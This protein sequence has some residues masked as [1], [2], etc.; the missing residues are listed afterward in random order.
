MKKFVDYIVNIKF[1]DKLNLFL[2]KT[3][4]L[5]VYIF[6]AVVIYKIIKFFLYK[7][8]ENKIS[9]KYISQKKLSL[10]HSIILNLIKYIIYFIAILIILKKVFNINPALIVTATGVLGLAVGLGIQNLLKDFISGLFILF[11]NKFNIGDYV[12]INNVKG[13]VIDINIKNISIV[14]FSGKINIIPNRLVNNIERSKDKKITVLFV[15]FIKE[16]P[17]VFNKIFKSLIKTLKNVFP[18]EI[19]D[20]SN[21][22]ERDKIG[23][24]R[25]IS[26]KIT[27][28]PYSDNIINFIKTLLEKNFSDIIIEYKII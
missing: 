16:P 13:K 20:I 24:F 14:D 25:Q 26:F 2:I 5:I 18:D 21:P 23:T 17:G 6:A 27:T 12:N 7:V 4:E 11:E 19:I 9:K 10:L 15:V 8:K 28:L 1:L 3:F 22:E